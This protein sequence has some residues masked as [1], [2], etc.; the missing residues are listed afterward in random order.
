M[1]QIEFDATMKQ[2]NYD[3]MVENQKY[4]EE[5]EQLDKQ[6]NDRKLCILALRQE[7]QTL[8]IQKLSLQ[9]WQKKMNQQM[10]EKKHR[11]C[12]EHPH[13]SMEPVSASQPPPRCLYGSCGSRRYSCMTYGKAS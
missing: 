11:F 6:I 13:D 10:H 8:H 12:M 7:I 2:M 9:S 5:K 1:T 3:Q 4:N